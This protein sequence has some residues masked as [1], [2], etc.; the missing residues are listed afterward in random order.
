MIITCSKNCRNSVSKS[1]SGSG[2]GGAT[3]TPNALLIAGTGAI[4]PGAAFFESSASPSTHCS[5]RLLSSGV[6]PGTLCKEGG[7]A[8]ESLGMIKTVP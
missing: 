2:I 6:G 8:W 7:K 5:A 1:G 3:G 4:A